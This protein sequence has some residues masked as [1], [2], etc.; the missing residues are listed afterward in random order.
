[1]VTSHKID[2]K[3]MGNRG[4]KSG[5]LKIPVKEQ[6]VDGGY[7]GLIIPKLRY[8]LMGFERNYQ[9]KILSKQLNIKNFDTL[10]NSQCPQPGAVYTGKANPINPWF[11]T[12]LI[13]AEGS[14]S[15]I[16]DR[17]QI[18]K[19]G[20]RVQSKF[21]I[22]LHKR[23]YNLLILLQEH[24]KGIGSIHV[25]S[26]Q[27]RVNFSVD[28][29]KDLAILINH[30]D[31]Y[32]LLTQKRA[33]FILFKEVVKLIKNKQHLSLDGLKQ[34]VNIKASMNL[35]LSDMLKSEFYGFVPV[36]RPI[37]IVKFIPEAN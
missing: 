8:T 12:G 9:V 33:D 34:I 21:Q 28:S 3:K 24:F 29:V 36:C 1:M 37:I 5:Y 20:W 26:K 15:I 19:L 30:F 13:D 31:K 11:W 23:D 32:P 35:G 25:D 27:N 18:R 14:F 16:I 6:R 2:E 4:S 22:G 7:F 17:N 10:I